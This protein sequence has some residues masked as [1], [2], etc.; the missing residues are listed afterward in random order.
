MKNLLEKFRALA[1]EIDAHPK[2]VLLS[3]QEFKPISDTEINDLEADIDLKI[4]KDIKDFYQLTNGIKLAWIH[5]E[6]EYFNS[7]EH[8][9]FILTDDFSIIQSQKAPQFDVISHKYGGSI[10]IKG[11]L[12]VFQDE[13]PINPYAIEDAYYIFDSFSNAYGAA[14][15][16]PDSKEIPVVTVSGDY[17]YFGLYNNSMSFL[18]Y[19]DFTIETKALKITRQ[20]LS[21]N[22]NREKNLNIF[23]NK[24]IDSWPKEFVWYEN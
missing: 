24:G 2:L 16:F 12:E 1:K 19:L 22:T 13:F 11:I 10:D 6:E 7:E 15:S 4:A 9:P 14:I 8:I 20:Y 3:Y 5:I 21:N 18:E 23:R 17:E